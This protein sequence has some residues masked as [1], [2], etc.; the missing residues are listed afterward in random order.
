MKLLDEQKRILLAQRYQMQN[1][2]LGDNLLILTVCWGAS[3][4]LSLSRRYTTP[5]TI[6]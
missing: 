1:W 6:V 4:G 3:P 5:G 2:Q